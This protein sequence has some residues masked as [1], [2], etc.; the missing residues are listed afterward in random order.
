[1]LDTAEKAFSKGEWL[2]SIAASNLVLAKRE[3]TTPVPCGE[4]RL[5]MED[6]DKG[7]WPCVLLANHSGNH[8]DGEGDEWT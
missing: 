7:K 3:A 1:M 2:Q 8:K 4:E 5:W 6:E